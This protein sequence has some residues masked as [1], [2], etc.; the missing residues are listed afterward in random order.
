MNHISQIPSK[1]HNNKALIVLLLFVLPPVGIY[2][3]FK[4]DTQKW[5]QIVYTLFASIVTLFLMSFIFM[6]F[7]P[8]YYYESGNS[9]MKKGN[10]ENA[11][12]DFENVYKT[13]KHYSDALKN[14]E[15]AKQKIKEQL[16]IKENKEKERITLEQK[17]AL[18][19]LEKLK[20]FQKQWSEKIVKYWKGDYFKKSILSSSSDTIYFQLI[21][22]ASTGNWQSSAEMNREI[23]Q[24]EYDSL[25]KQKF[26]NEFANVKTKITI[27]PDS[28]QQ[29]EN[30]I[31]ARRQHLINRQF[32]GFSG[33]NRYVEDYIKERMND[34]DSYKH[35]Q[36]T[37][38]DKGS[39]I[40]VYTRFRGTNSIGAIIVQSATAKVDI[41]GNVLSLTY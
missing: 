21:K 23:Y 39:Y 22:V 15:L 29:K 14:I 41:D 26:G 7:N 8:D 5:K 38:K 11:I 24:R 20:D 12:K 6:L 28:E 3:I 40:L 17:E 19:K 31:I 37:Y 10:Y 25:V 35:I 2:C 9:N 18:K 16:V 13:D 1:W 33:A 27:V 4:R 36:T 30:E 32:A 34:P